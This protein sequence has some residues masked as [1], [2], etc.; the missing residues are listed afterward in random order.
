M[1]RIIG[2]FE[3]AH[4][5]SVLFEGKDITAVPPYKRRV[6]TVFQKYALFHPPERA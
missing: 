6:N 5:G 1:L 2:G 4:Q 3:Y